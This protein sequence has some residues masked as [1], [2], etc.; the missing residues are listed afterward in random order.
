MEEFTDE[1]KQKMKEKIRKDFETISMQYSIQS[2]ITQ[3]TITQS[4][5]MSR[6]RYSEVEE[7]E[8]YKEVSIK[9]YSYD[10]FGMKY[11]QALTSDLEPYVKMYIDTIINGNPDKMMVAKKWV[12]DNKNNNISYVL[13]VLNNTERDLKSIIENI[14]RDNK[15][16]DLLD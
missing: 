3:S 10:L 15:L 14:K 7:F 8:G 13:S 16:N 1:E 9:I 4:N 11:F 6:N 2:T 12:D 5:P